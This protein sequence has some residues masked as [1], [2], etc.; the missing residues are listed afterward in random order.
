MIFVAMWVV[1]LSVIG[2]KL[3]VCQLIATGALSVLNTP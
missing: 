3:S 1:Y 2:D